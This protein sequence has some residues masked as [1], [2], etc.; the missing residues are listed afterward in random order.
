MFMYSA[1]IIYTYIYYT[2][3]SICG[4]SNL[5]LPPSLRITP[6]EAKHNPVQF[7]DNLTAR[8]KSHYTLWKALEVE[9]ASTALPVLAAWEGR[10]YS[11][12]V[13]SAVYWPV[14]I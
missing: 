6:L 10:R 5:P 12:G 7:T 3:K 4:I 13:G 1:Y 14:C 9:V 2:H 11:E 8:N